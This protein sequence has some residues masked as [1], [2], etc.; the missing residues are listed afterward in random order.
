MKKGNLI[1]AG[2]C[3]ILSV[4][5]IAVASTY[6]TAEDYGTGVPG[7]GLWPTIIAVLLL[8]CSGILVYR[9]FFKMKPEED[10]KLDL[11]SSNHCR[12]YISMAILF[13][14]T[15]VL[16][17]VGYIISTTVMEFVFIQWFGKKKPWITLLISLAITLISYFAF[18]NLLNVPVD[19][20]F[21]A[22]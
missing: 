10:V 20:G 7:P 9:T 16:H 14:Y 19:F 12:V 18:K 3:A 17:P 13:V 15:L 2:L 21:F 22:L 4:I 5:I 6:P 1:S 11:L 8:I